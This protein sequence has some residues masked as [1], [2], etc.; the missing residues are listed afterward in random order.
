M[1]L[2]TNAVSAFADGDPEVLRVASGVTTF[3]LPAVVLGEFRFGIARSRHRNRYV[4]WLE[5]FISASTV[6]VIDEET[7]RH[8]ADLR[9]SLRVTGRPIPSNDTWIAALA[10]QHRLPVLS[11]DEHLHGIEGVRAIAW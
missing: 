1:I 10:I 11:R 8:Y 9:E 6:L 4:A 5:D 3:S 7:S 2:D